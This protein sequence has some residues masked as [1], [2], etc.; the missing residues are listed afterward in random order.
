MTLY[1]RW[2]ALRVS[3]LGVTEWSPEDISATRC[4]LFKVQRQLKR[5]TG[6]TC[7]MFC[8]KNRSGWFCLLLG[9]GHESQTSS[10]D[11]RKQMKSHTQTEHHKRNGVTRH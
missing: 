6:A 5:L 4:E 10:E 1:Y 8:N 3:T 7:A 9:I 11:R 2:E